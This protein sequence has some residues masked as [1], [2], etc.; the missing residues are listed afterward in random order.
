MNYSKTDRWG[1]DEL[2]VLKTGYIDTRGLY[3]AMGSVV[4]LAVVSLLDMQWATTDAQMVFIFY[5]LLIHQAVEQ[6]LQ[7]TDTYFLKLKRETQVALAMFTEIISLGLVFLFLTSGYTVK[8]QL[9]FNDMLLLMNAV[10]L[11]IYGVIIGFVIYREAKF[12]DDK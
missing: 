10:F 1:R 2:Q 12:G 6:N 8:Q 5:I 7:L 4:I 9:A 3:I 11:V